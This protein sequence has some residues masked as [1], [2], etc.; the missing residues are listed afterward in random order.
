MRAAVFLAPY[1]RVKRSRPIFM[2]RQRPAGALVRKKIHV[3]NT[4]ATTWAQHRD[5][6]L[7]PIFLHNI[8]R[9]PPEG[10]RE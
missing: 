7:E 4:L 1:R 3:K 2:L 9:A 5:L 10:V 8:E 6:F